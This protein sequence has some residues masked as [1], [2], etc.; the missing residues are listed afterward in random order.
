MKKTVVRIISYVLVAVVAASA[1]LMLTRKSDKLHELEALIQERFIGEADTQAMEDAAAS[2]MV[3][4][5]GDRWSYYMTAEGYLSYQEAMSNSYVGVGVTIQGR[6]DQQGFDIIEV[7]ADGPAHTAGIQVGDRLIAVGDDSAIGLTTSEVSSLV[8]GEPETK[9]DLT[10]VRRTYLNT[11][12]LVYIDQTLSDAEARAMAQQIA[13]VDNVAQCTFVSREEALDDFI[14][15]HDDPA[16]DGVDAEELRHRCVVTL[17]ELG[18]ME[19]TAALLEKMD[20]VA[21][22][23]KPTFREEEK[24]F[25]VTRRQF[26][27]PVATGQLLEGNIGLVTIENF[28]QRCADETIAAIEALVEQGAEALI[29]DVRNNPGGFK[30]ELVEVLDYLLPEGPLFRAEDYRGAE[31]VDYSDEDCLDLPM[32]VLVNLNSY[33]AAEFFAAAL[34]EY[35]AAVVVGEQTYGKGYFQN[36][37]ALSD[38]SAVTLSVGRYY[39]PNGVS[40]AGV[41]LEPDVEIIV[42]EETAAKIYTDTLQPMEDP[43]IAAA[44]NAL[45]SGN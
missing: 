19:Q 33:S 39:T 1:T 23:T 29:F 42:D 25:P 43:Q 32:A 36:T 8:R 7:V 27:T 26:E 31:Q 40:L 38:G 41:G 44:I 37:Y 15:D 18:L 4:A 9:V 24:T 6:E 13:A 35:D 14:A 2:A 16:F 11:E 22:V 12:I 21:E 28:D 34:G 20:G 30:S 5:L 3:S 10:V 17:E 45:K